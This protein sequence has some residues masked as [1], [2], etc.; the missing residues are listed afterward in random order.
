MFSQNEQEVIRK[1]YKKELL[2]PN[3]VKTIIQNNFPKRFI[4]LNIK[5]VLKEFENIYNDIEKKD[6]SLCDDG[7][8]AQH[9]QVMLWV[10]ELAKELPN[11]DIS[12][13]VD[14]ELPD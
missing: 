8:S 3:V 1:F 11:Y 12:N 6:G 4:E 7:Y 10:L 5:N 9:C 13:I 2:N 14:T